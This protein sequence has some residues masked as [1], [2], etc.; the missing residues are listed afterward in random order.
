MT[1]VESGQRR[2][3][4]VGVVG[5]GVVATAYYLPFL[6]RYA[7]L[8]A[9]CDTNSRR[10]EQ[11]ARLFGV[12]EQYDDYADMLARSDIEA[13][14]ILTAPGTHVPFTLAAVESGR[15]VLVQKPMAT[16][17]EDARRI[18]AAVRAAGVKALIEPSA[19]SPLDPQ[20][21]PLRELV[22]NGVL[23]RPYWFSLVGGAPEAYGPSLGGNPY[24]AGAFYAADSGGFLFDFPYAPN[25]IASVLGSCRAVTGMAKVSVPDGAIVPDS[26]YDR[27][28]GTAPGPDDANYWDVVTDLPRTQQVRMEAEDNVFSVYEMESGAIGVFHCARPRHPQPA[29][30]GGGGLQVFGTDGNLFLGAG[31]FASIITSRRELLPGVDA[32]GWYRIPSSGDGR[33]AKWPKPAPGGF[34]YYHE[35]ARHLLDCITDDRDPVV[36]VEWG[37]HITEMMYG[38]LQAARTGR[39]YDM[40][41]RLPGGW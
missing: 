1:S 5:C 33:T 7:D 34:N 20:Y 3:V 8:V 23:G 17:V 26:E 21:G 29:G 32:D 9:V 6:M 30:W 27:F 11:C 15:H 22:R 39:R 28:L 41:T 38:A 24:G 16:N 2:R 37:L 36:N 31:Q 10:T 12:P 18:A 14:F 35:S 4:R 13:V 25:Q 19:N 40:T